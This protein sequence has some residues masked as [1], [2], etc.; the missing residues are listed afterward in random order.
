MLSTLPA[1]PLVNNQYFL[2]EL[3]QEDSGDYYGH[4]EYL[5]L[6]EF[7]SQKEVCTDRRDN[8]NDIGEDIGFPY[9][10]LPY[11]NCYKYESQT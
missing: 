6:C 1:L 10:K 11:G 9:T 2:P 8:G 3:C 5:S 4:P 7:L